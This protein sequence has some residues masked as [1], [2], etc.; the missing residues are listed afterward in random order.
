ML[1][2][3]L[4][5]CAQILTLALVPALP[6]AAQDVSHVELLPGWQME[7]GH[8]MTGV[9]VTLDPGWKTYWRAPGG[10]G[11][12]PRFDFSGSDNVR[13]TRIHWPRPEVFND[14]AG[15]TIGYQS[16]VIFPVEII[17]DTP[18]A[19]VSLALTFDYGVCEEVCIPASAR[20]AAD[21]PP[22]TRGA[23]PDIRASLAT[24]ALSAN[25]AGVAS[26]TCAIAPAGEDFD[27]TATLTYTGT[28]DAGA[29]P[30]FETGSDLIWISPRAVSRAGRD[31]R[32]EGKLFHYDSGPLTLD[33]SQIRLTLLSP[34][35]MVELTGC[36]AG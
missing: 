30:V 35:R 14:P 2:P 11:I 25:A 10:N 17:P 18:G 5:R 20:L 36:P 29:Y 27:L 3:A 32:I 31:L 21:L 19:P 34:D 7:N 6:G 13:A 26:V 22:A 15:R 23:E 16:E 33:R 28:P 24:R 1:R 4:A 12:P 8:R 9:H